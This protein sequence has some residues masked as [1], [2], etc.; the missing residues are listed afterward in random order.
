VTAKKQEI[1]ATFPKPC[2]C[3]KFLRKTQGKKESSGILAGMLFSPKKKFP[4]NRNYQPSP[5]LKANSP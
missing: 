2:S 3:E 1:P 4:E 5:K